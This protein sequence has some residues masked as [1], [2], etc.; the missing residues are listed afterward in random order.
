[1]QTINWIAL[2]RMRR[3]IRKEKFEKTF[4]L[5]QKYDIYT[6]IDLI[7]GLPGEDIFAI[8]ETLE[9]MVD[10]LRDSKAHLLC[11][12]VM[13]GL[14]G[15]ELMEIAKIPIYFSHAITDTCGWLRIKSVKINKIVLNEMFLFF[16]ELFLFLILSW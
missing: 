5:L 12:H 6:K 14:P 1:M 4:K 2:K 16:L 10:Q 13:R 3:P 15:T 7:I 8:E 11:C 9:Y